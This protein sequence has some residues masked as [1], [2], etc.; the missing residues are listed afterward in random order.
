MRRVYHLDRGY[1]HIEEK[2]GALGASIERVKGEPCALSRS[3]VVALPKGRIRE[4]ARRR[5][6][7]AR[8][9]T[10]APLDRERSLAGRATAAARSRFLL[11]KPDDVPT[12]VEYG[13]ADLG[14]CGRDVLRERRVGP[15]RAA[16]SRHRALPHGR[17]RPKAGAR[18]DPD[19]PRVATKYPR[20]A[21][22]HFARARRAGRD[23]HA[24]RLGR[25]RAA[26][27]ARRPHRRPRRDRGDAPAERAGSRA[28]KCRP[29]RRCSSSIARP[30]SCDAPKSARSSNGFARR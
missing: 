15:L 19:V 14:V 29:S 3:L 4:G 27:R 1:E 20:I 8:A 11:L 24:A 10:R 22:A 18:R 21:A 25:A 23:H 9:S 16:R 26:R 17:R 30:T 6:S 12:Y 2:L 7:R 5:S 28:R 13:A